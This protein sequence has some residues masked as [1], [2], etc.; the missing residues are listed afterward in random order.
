MRYI[1]AQILTS[2]LAENLILDLSN[3]HPIWGWG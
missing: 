3:S 1:V 2:F